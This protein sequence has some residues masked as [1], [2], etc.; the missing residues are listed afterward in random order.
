MRDNDF[1]PRRR[2]R[3]ADLWLLF[4]QAVTIILALVFV[5]TLTNP[6]RGNDE[7]QTPAG[8]DE[9]TF[10]HA[11]ERIM[12]SVVSIRTFTE[13]DS[14][15]EPVEYVNL[16]SG[17][18]VSPSGHVITNMHVVDDAKKIVVLTNEG[19]EIAAEILGWDQDIDL[20]VLQLITA[21]EL[22]AAK[23]PAQDSLKV[24]D[25]VM[26]VGSP[27]GLANTA[28][29]GIVSATG[30]NNLGLSDY[31]YFIQTDAA[32][33]HG[34]SGGALANVRGE[35]VGINT[36]LFAKRF[37]GSLAQG[38]G[39]AIP[40]ELVQAVYSEIVRYGRFRRGWIGVGLSNY[41]DTPAYAD[42]GVLHVD[43]VDIQS[44]A[45]KAGVRVGDL[46]LEIDGRQPAS[47]SFMEE[48]SGQLLKPGEKLSLKINRDG[49]EFTTAVD[50][51]EIQTNY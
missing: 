3:L 46:I 44:P 25:M 19:E 43:S 51:I 20:A 27:Y 10:R 48:A 31:E 11:L 40:V 39:F 30:R 45:D 7:T 42:A 8:S 21:K 28:S 37:E 34:S 47:I 6:Q 32:I 22:V 9:I 23:F 38:I 12:P 2:F 49:R 4:A 13:E 36:A 18:I 29:I 35:V 24:G 17:V 14:A 33:N 50:V 1:A 16:G 26:S 41:T 5:L 15:D